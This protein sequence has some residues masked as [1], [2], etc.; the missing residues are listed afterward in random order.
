MG[1]IWPMVGTIWNRHGASCC[2]PTRLKFGPYIASWQ[3][4]SK[5]R[6]RFEE[7]PEKAPA[8]SGACCRLLGQV[9]E[10]ASQQ[11]CS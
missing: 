5:R 4:L 10:Q 1:F 8:S 2:G 3:V 7:V 11:F 6:S 9:R